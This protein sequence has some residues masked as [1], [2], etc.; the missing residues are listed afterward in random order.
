MAFDLKQFRSVFFDE[1]D[2]LL[3]AIAA[4]LAHLAPG[5]DAASA[6]RDAYRWA[7]SVKGSSSTFGY[8]DITAIAGALAGVFEAV[9][10]GRQVFDERVM[11]GCRTAHARLVELLAARRTE[12]GL[13]GEETTAVVDGAVAQETEASGG[14]D[15]MDVLR[16][17]AREIHAM[18]TRMED[19][20]REQA[21]LA[22]RTEAAL[23][24]FEMQLKWMDRL[25]AAAEEK[26]AGMPGDDAGEVAQGVK[27][28]H[29]RNRVGPLPK[30]RGGHGL[31]DEWEDV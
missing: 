2:E 12:A 1:A 30:V 10:E 4:T 18:V 11:E 8:S 26:A 25:V 5:A 20:T 14:A 6:M 29:R 23:L 16:A 21:V 9:A 13:G 22:G 27:C 19:L 28:R 24:Q 17:T 3:A 7:H 31:V 15:E